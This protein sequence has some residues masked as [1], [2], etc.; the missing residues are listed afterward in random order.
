MPKLVYLASPYSHRYAYMRE[1]RYEQVCKQAARLME[2][3]YLVFCPIAHSHPI[4]ILG[5][6]KRMSG[7]WWLKQDFAILQHCNEM[8]VYKIPGWD[9]SYGVKEE[10]KFAKKNNIPVKYIEYDDT[11]TT[12]QSAA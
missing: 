7:D 11:A 5:L 1:R 8:H 3:G 6:P 10:I 4:E 2:D 12:N 9:K